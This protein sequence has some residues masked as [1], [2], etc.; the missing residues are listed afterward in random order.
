MT[1]SWLVCHLKEQMLTFKS[2]NLIWFFF[3]IFPLWCVF[4]CVFKCSLSSNL[5]FS[6]EG[7]SFPLL[8]PSD[9]L[10][11][12]FLI[13]C[14][15]TPNCMITHP[16]L[17]KKKRKKTLGLISLLSFYHFI[18]YRNCRLP[19]RSGYKK[20]YCSL[21]S[22]NWLDCFVGSRLQRA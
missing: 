3:L 10:F 22:Y 5:T 21:Q 18:I 15:V 4:W 20:L 1:N 9:S 17:I 12:F 8:T 2:T 13:C 11:F 19:R 6:A 16:H 7:Q 14:F